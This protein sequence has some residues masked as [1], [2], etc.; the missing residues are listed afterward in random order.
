MTLRISDSTQSSTNQTNS[1]NTP[2]KILVTLSGVNASSEEEAAALLKALG[3]TQ[4]DLDAFKE[5]YG[6]DL[7]KFFADEFAKQ[8]SRITRD[9]SSKPGFKPISA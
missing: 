8:P 1:L 3:F 9:A 2:E 7:K 4:A 6:K 5:K